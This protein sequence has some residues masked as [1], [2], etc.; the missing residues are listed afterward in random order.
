MRVAWQSLSLLYPYSIPLY[1]RKGWEIVSDKMAFR[2]KDTQLPRQVDA[3]GF[4]RRVEE[5]SPDL[6]R[7]HTRYAGQTHGCIY[8]ND[9][10]WEEYWRWDVDD[11]EVALYYSEGGDPLGYMVY[12][13]K[14]EVMHIKE[15]VYLNHEAW[16]GLWKYISA[17]ESMV[18]AVSGSNYSNEPIAFWLED[19]DIK[20]TI[21][22][23][24]MGRI[25]D[26]EQFLLRYPFL[27][28]SREMAVTLAVSDP[29]LDWNSRSFTLRFAPGEGMR[30]SDAPC[31]AR[32]TLSIGTLTTLLLG[33]KTP[34]YLAE[35]ERLAATPEALRVLERV[36]P[37]EKPHIAD[38]I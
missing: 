12:L 15:L 21:R 30:L 38:Y 3:P 16:R 1:R 27:P 6:I 33:Y 28:V 10:A 29:L 31:D 20:E 8:R 14:D 19:S 23:Y 17:H 2:L 26:A 36:L 24:I 37:R 25:V 11:T 5:N 13:L 9:L 4:V 22:P 18:E 34:Q 32:V 7:L 35:M